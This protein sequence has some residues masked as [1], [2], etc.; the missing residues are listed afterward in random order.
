MEHTIG[1][2]LRRIKGLA[3]GLGGDQRE[4]LGR[5]REQISFA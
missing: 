5:P 1:G 3:R 2:G 4:K